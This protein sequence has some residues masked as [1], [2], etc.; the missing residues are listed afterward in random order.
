MAELWFYPGMLTSGVLG[1][2]PTEP[3]LASGSELS[4]RGTSACYLFPK[5]PDF[6]PAPATPRC[7]RHRS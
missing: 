3:S 1:S 5:P 7:A 4:D 6:S 2:I